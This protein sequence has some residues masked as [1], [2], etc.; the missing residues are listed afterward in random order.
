[1]RRAAGAST[2]SRMTRDSLLRQYGWNL[3]YAEALSQ[4]VPP[5][6]WARSGG[7]GL[8]NHPAWTIGHLV[9]GSAMVADDLGVGIELPASWTELFLRQGPSDR[10]LPD[11]SAPYPDRET[12]LGEL[13]R[14]HAAVSD[15]LAV[16]EMDTL[17]HEEAW[18]FDGYLPT[19]LDSIVFMLI[20]HEN[21]HLGQLGCWRRRFD[22][23]SA[24]AAM[25]RGGT[26][27]AGEG[28]E[29][30]QFRP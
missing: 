13:A 6:L 5:D 28:L 14:V 29:P 10:R 9:T 12:L 3:A 16:V 23:P 8:E 17:K 26:G 19:R 7:P 22:L 2:L 18:R 1:M 20:A 15:A 4:D 11:A 30:P 25:P 27:R 24:M 21:V